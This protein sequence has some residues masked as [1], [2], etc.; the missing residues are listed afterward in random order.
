MIICLYFTLLVGENAAVAVAP[1]GRRKDNIN[2]AFYR[3]GVCF[4]AEW[5]V[6]GVIMHSLNYSGLFNL[7]WYFLLVSE[8]TYT[9]V[10]LVCCFG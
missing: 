5:V 2:F 6:A 7:N 8:N 9:L 1:F 3:V 10:W 4:N